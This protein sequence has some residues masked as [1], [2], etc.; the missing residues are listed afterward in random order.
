M[1]E[2]WSFFRCHNVEF[3]QRLPYILEIANE[4]FTDELMRF[5]ICFR[6]FGMGMGL[7]ESSS[8]EETGLGTCGFITLFCLLWQTSTIVYLTKG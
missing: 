2:F 3:F 1:K 6:I 4:I 5:R 7:A 8:R